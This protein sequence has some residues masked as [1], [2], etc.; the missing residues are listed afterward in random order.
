MS[1]FGGFASFFMYDL[2]STCRYGYRPS[3]VTQHS[4]FDVDRNYIQSTYS[5]TSS[6]GNQHDRHLLEPITL[7]TSVH[8]RIQ[9]VQKV[10]LMRILRPMKLS[11]RSHGFS[12]R[13]QHICYV[14]RVYTC[15]T[16]LH[17]HIR[18][19]PFTYA[20][21]DPA[22]YDTAAAV[23][24]VYLGCSTNDHPQTA[25]VFRLPPR[26]IEGGEG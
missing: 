18:Y 17:L 4:V 14:C 26:G 20:G 1:W 2:V 12:P 24:I 7:G 6:D 23:H 22:A 11:F 21:H 16:S 19:C 8:P 10:T 5:S 3:C 25:T 15:Q 9:Q 13:V